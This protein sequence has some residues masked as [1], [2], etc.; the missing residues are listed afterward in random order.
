[1][2][3]TLIIHIGWHKTATT[4]IQS[5]LSQYRKELVKYCVCY[6]VIEVR[7]VY[8]KIKH[9]D[10]LA[11][12]L[13]ELKPG[14]HQFDVRTFDELFEV[15][16][17]EIADSNCRLSII[18][19]EG[20]SAPMPLIAKYM[21]R[22]KDHFDEVKIV[23]YL[24]RQDY[25]LESFYSQ[26]V[27]QEVSKCKGRFK[28]FMQWPDTRKRLD[29]D[30]ILGWWADEFGKENVIVGQFERHIIV[31]DPITHFFGL[32]GLPTQVLDS[33]PVEREQLNIS[34]P[35]EITEYFRFMNAKN[36]KFNERVL[37]EYLLNS[38][39]LLTNTKYLGYTDRVQLLRDY[40]NCNSRVARNYLNSDDGVLFEEPVQDYENSPETW[41][42]LR[43]FEI[44]DYAMSVTGKMSMEISR[45]RNENQRINGLKK[46]LYR[47]LL[48][49]YRRLAGKKTNWS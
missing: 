15:S 31:P 39:A 7:S 35:R 19:E 47:I 1:M 33:Y 8:G 9:C 30:M 34:L 23:A 27:K 46:I 25:Y 21:G 48:H 22:Y 32:T 11:S 16:L 29:Y 18:S 42:G 5:Y 13:N 43:P 26:I 14:K 17:R 20:F 3:K 4:V 24:R 2:K 37:A 40:E 49:V 6:P 28:D 41:N 44:L 36:A 45:L 10:Y 38:G 12:I